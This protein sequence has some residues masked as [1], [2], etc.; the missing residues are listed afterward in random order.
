M[1]DVR[2]F[3]VLQTPESSSIIVSIEICVCG[4]IP[5][6]A[7]IVRLPSLFFPEYT[8]TKVSTKVMM[9]LTKSLNKSEVTLMKRSSYRPEIPQETKDG[10][11]N[12]YA[13]DEFLTCDKIAQICKVSKSSVFRI[14]RESSV[15]RRGKGR[16]SVTYYCVEPLRDLLAS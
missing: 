4:H 8:L 7:G 11:I 13:N 16:T 15:D 9:K 5:E 12:L 10:I 1:P 14:L 6:G 3:L 2:Y